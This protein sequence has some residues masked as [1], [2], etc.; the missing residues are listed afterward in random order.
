M[1]TAEDNVDT[2][3]VKM[4]L[5][6][7]S[8]FGGRTMPQSGIIK[9]GDFPLSVKGNLCAILNAVKRGSFYVKESFTSQG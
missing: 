2:L 6:T 4:T 3:F 7:C 8:V 5:A 9:T 1:Q